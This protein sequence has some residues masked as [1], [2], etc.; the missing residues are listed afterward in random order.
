MRESEE[1][2]F[3]RFSCYVGDCIVWTGTL[4]RPGGYGVLAVQ[5]R[6]TTMGAH[7]YAW[8]RVHGP[9]PKGMQIDHICKVKFCV[10]VNHLRL[11]TPQENSLRDLSPHLL[12]NLAKTHCPKGHEYNAENTRIYRNWR[13][14]RACQKHMTGWMSRL[15]AGARYA[16]ALNGHKEA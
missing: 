7:R 1:S 13:Y 2:Q 4:N 12:R 14:C 16:E 15:L 11:A 9:I 8:E 10:N 3:Q 6:N 5:N